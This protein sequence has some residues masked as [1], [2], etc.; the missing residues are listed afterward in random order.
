MKKT[1]KPTPI[2]RVKLGKAK[3]ECQAAAVG[4][5]RCDCPKCVDF[6]LEH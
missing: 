3:P 2:K 5:K 1:I 4:I 6:R